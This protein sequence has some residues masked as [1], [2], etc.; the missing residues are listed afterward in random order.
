M[1]K[2]TSAG[3]CKSTTD[4]GIHERL[5]QWT[6]TVRSNPHADH[7]LGEDQKRLMLA[8]AKAV[9]AAFPKFFYFEGRKYTLGAG[10][11][12]SILDVYKHSNSS[13]PMVSAPVRLSRVE[14]RLLD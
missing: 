9:G 14:Q 6:K 4:F 5:D 2:S 1:N 8:A 7:P 10:C 11:L 13:I 3:A 12:L